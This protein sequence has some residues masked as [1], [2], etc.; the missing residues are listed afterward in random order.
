MLVNTDH[1]SEKFGPELVVNIAH[2][3][4]LPD[5]PMR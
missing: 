4:E 2:I 5:Q 3:A 1:L